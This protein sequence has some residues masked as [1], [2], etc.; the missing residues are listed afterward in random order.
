MALSV[1]M[2]S[3]VSVGKP[4]PV[5]AAASRSSGW[6]PAPL[7]LSSSGRLSRF[8]VRAEEGKEE[9]KALYADEEPETGF[10]ESR[11]MPKSQQEKLR[12]EYEGLGGSPD[13]VSC[14]L[15]CAMR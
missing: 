6:F 14:L 5:P 4:S 7:P 12:R 2:R 9:P 11:Q 10:F 1:C 8:T 15:L 13:R 3:A